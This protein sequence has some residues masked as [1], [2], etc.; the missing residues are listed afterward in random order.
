MIILDENLSDFN[1]DL[2]GLLRLAIL[3]FGASLS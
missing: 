3:S 1:R 2:I